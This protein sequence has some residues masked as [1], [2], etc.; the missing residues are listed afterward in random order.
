MKITLRILVGA[1]IIAITLWGVGVLYFSPLL[2]EAW[3]PIG[4][5]G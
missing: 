5:G 1:G 4:A 3:R 2:P